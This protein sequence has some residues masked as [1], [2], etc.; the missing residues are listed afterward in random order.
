[1]DA[2]NAMNAMH[3]MHAMNEWKTLF[4]LSVFKYLNIK[5]AMCSS[6]IN[7]ITCLFFGHQAEL[8][9]QDVSFSGRILIS[10]RIIHKDHTNIN[11]QRILWRWINQH[12][13]S[14]GP[15]KILSLRQESNP[16]PPE[17]RAG[18]L[19]TELRELMESKVI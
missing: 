11:T 15:S 10:V 4:Y 12:D 6:V 19:S 13:T 1:M 17:H 8:P 18:A 9:R 5:A 7:E 2:I 14:V 3:A 16:W